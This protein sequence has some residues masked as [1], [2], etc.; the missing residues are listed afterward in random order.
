MERKQEPTSWQQS[1]GKK[2]DV[3]RIDQSSWLLSIF[4]G[5]YALVCAKLC[6]NQHAV[7]VLQG[8]GNEG[9]CSVKPQP[10]VFSMMLLLADSVRDIEGQG[11][12]SPGGQ[13]S[14]PSLWAPA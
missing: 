4:V 10:S 1:K 7:Y 9:G 5:Q 13:A 2:C 3:S 12:G 11:G 6:L 14:L 8:V